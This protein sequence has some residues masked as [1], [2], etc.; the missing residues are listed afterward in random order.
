MHLSAEFAKIDYS[1]DKIK[2][3]GLSEVKRLAVSSCKP[4]A[5]ILAIAVLGSKWKIWMFRWLLSEYFLWRVK[6]T[7][8][9]ELSLII[10]YMMNQ[11]GFI[12]SIRLNAIH[13]IASPPELIEEESSQED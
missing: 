2:S 8:M 10:N 5:N 6:P 9:L 7:K 4:L 1:E 13:K 11:E 12:T 3:D